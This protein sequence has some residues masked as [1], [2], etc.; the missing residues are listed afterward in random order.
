MSIKLTK[1]NYLRHLQCKKA[2]WLYKYRQDLMS[3]VDLNAQRVFDT[4]YEVESIAYTMFP[5]GV[6]TSDDIAKS[7]IETNELLHNKSPIIFQATVSDDQLFCRSDIIEYD[8]YNDVWNIIE[9]KSASSV[10]DVYID[11]LAFQKVCFENIGYKV[12]NLSVIHINNQYVKNGPIVATD[13]LMRTD[14]TDEVE[15]RLD[16]TKMEIQHALEVL[17]EQ[18]EPD[19]RVVRQCNDPYECPFIAYCWKDFPEHSIY[20]I[21]GALGKKRI[22]TLLEMGVMDIADIPEDMMTNE[23]LLRHYRAVKNDEVYVDTERIK[24]ELSNIQYPVY[25]LDYETYGPT[26][27][28]IDGYKPFQRVVFQ[29]SLHIQESP[30]ALCK[31]VAFLTN[32]IQ[33]PTSKMAQSLKEHIGNHGTIIAWH[34]AFEKGCNTEMGERA[35]EYA[36]FFDN[37]NE[38]MFDL[39]NIFKKGYYV[40]KNFFTSASIKKVLPVMVPE[41]DYGK[42]DISEGMTASNSWGDMVTGGLPQ[43]QKEKIYNDLLLYCELD[44]LAMVR[45]LEK[46][47]N[48]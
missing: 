10:K 1:S 27:P 39:M 28:I 8:K 14:V 38:R 12:G 9:V 46:L 21:G 29:Y 41:L 19:V 6:T 3:E 37:I 22:N 43:D 20:S 15:K 26:I 24:S 30:G 35:P 34:I 5:G 40:H 13:F 33:D 32:D 11:D 25:Y 36:Q 17:Q 2:L 16:Y 23:K 44:T 48:L 45:I 31:H 7:I 4:G 47:Q 42:L 18:H